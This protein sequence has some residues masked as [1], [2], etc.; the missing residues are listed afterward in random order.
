MPCITLQN[1][2]TKPT[3]QN[4]ESISRGATDREI[5]TRTSS[6]CRAFWKLQWKQNEDA[7]QRSSKHQRSHPKCQGLHSFRIV[8]SRLGM[9][10]ARA[11][12][13]H[14]FSLPR[15]QSHS[16]YVEPL[17]KCIHTTIQDSA[18]VTDSLPSGDSHHSNESEV[19][20]VTIQLVL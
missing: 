15:I 2:T 16:P 18:T 17:T 7:S 19:I 1:S 9:H 11:E 5:L 8:P 6:R 13:Y 4:L 12:D 10:C 3:G 20:R 14:C